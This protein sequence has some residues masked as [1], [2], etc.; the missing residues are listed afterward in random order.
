MFPGMDLIASYTARERTFARNFYNGDEADAVLTGNGAGYFLFTAAHSAITVQ[1]GRRKFAD[2]FTGALALTLGELTGSACLA[3][4]GTVSEWAYWDERRDS[5]TGILDEGIDAGR[6]V[7]DLNGVSPR[8]GADMFI[9]YGTTPSDE[10][11]ALADALVYEFSEYR[12]VAGG[13]LN[14]TSPR[15]VR[16]YVAGQGGDGIQLEIAPRLI[17][18]DDNPFGPEDFITRLAGVLSAHAAQHAPLEQP[19]AA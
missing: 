6:F 12:V 19:V 8:Y 3:A 9:G 7:V 18:A 11:L 5:F 1:D 10:A 15:T 14:A 4:A 13:K 16:S 2:P 17:N